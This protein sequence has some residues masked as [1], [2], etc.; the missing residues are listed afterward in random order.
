MIPKFTLLLPALLKLVNGAVVLSAPAQ[1]FAGVGG[2]G[3]WWPHDLYQFPESVRKNLS[4][5]LFSQ[6]GLGLSSYRYNLGGGGLGVSN[7]VRAP[8]T[9]YVSKGVYN[10]SADA[11]GLYFLKAAADRQV[12]QLT[13]FVNSGPRDFTTNGYSCG[14]LFKNGTEAA[15][16]QYIADSLDHLIHSLSIPISYLSPFNE[17]DSSFGPVPCGQEGMQTNANQ[18]AAVIEGVY[19]GLVAKGLQ[20]TVGIMADESSNLASAQSEYSTWL[21]KVLDKV[22]VLCHHTYDFPTDS[23]YLNYINYVKSIAPTKQTWMSLVPFFLNPV[24]ALNRSGGYDPTYVDARLY[25]QPPESAV[26]SIRGGLHFATLMMQS[27]I[28]A[29]EPHYDF[30]TLVSNDV[31]TFIPHIRYT[32]VQLPPVHLENIYVDTG[33]NLQINLASHLLPWTQSRSFQKNGTVRPVI[34]ASFDPFSAVDW[35]TFNSTTLDLSG[36]TPFSQFSYNVSVALVPMFVNKTVDITIPQVNNTPITFTTATFSIHVLS[37]G[38]SDADLKGW[39][40]YLLVIISVIALTGVVGVLATCFWQDLCCPWRSRPLSNREDEKVEEVEQPG[41][42]AG[43]LARNLSRKRH[44]LE[45]G[46]I[47]SGDATGCRDLRQVTPYEIVA[48]PVSAPR[49]LTCMVKHRR[50]VHGFQVVQTIPSDAAGVQYVNTSVGSLFA[51]GINLVSG[52]PVEACTVAQ[53]SYRVHV[54]PYPPPWMHFCPDR[55]ILWGTP[56]EDLSPPAVLKFNIS[57]ISSASDLVVGKLSLGVS[58]AGPREELELSSSHVFSETEKGVWYEHINGID[59]LNILSG[60]TYTIGYHPQALVGRQVQPGRYHFKCSQALPSW[61]AFTSN[62]LEI[63]GD[64]TGYRRRD[65]RDL[66]VVDRFTERVIAKLRVTLV[67]VEDWV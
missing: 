22:A 18:R 6:A 37:E 35:L 38:T 1:T 67:V 40:P 47:F 19:S 62:P 53:T 28:V 59:T 49:R 12:P 10:W 44:M 20:N 39:A 8:E 15:Y 50:F 60:T 43:D 61:L 66:W 21:P 33:H 24:Y 30:W 4:D 26:S 9:F 41:N 55:L 27:F 46:G 16:G 23:S 34:F 3:A 5:L 29:G 42:S 7:P 54:T 48:G 11:Q 56:S 31:S 17:P 63:R 51:V 14:G 65:L 36:Q 25:D 58:A 64:T 32:E 13:V 52:S 2:S 57:L 45:S